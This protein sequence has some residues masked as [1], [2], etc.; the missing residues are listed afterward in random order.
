M[1]ICYVLTLEFA[2]CGIQIHNKA[3]P[4]RSLQSIY[5]AVAKIQK[6]IKV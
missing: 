5:D 1:N 3:W 6:I 4:A 2:L